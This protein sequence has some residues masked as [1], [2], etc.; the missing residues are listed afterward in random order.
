VIASEEWG[1]P[2]ERLRVPP[3]RDGSFEST[4]HDAAVGNALVLFDGSDDGA[5]KGLDEP[6]GHRAIGV[7]YDPDHERWGN[8]VPTILPRR[9]DAFLYIDETRAVDPLHMPVRV[10]GEAPETYPSGE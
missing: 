9:Y 10:D 3:A 7:V 6:M 1:A 8:Y 4:M 2:M 5:V